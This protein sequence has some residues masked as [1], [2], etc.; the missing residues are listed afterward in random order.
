[1][2]AHR[3]G[4]DTAGSGA[5]SGQRVLEERTASGGG[6]VVPGLRPVAGGPEALR[7]A[8]PGASEHEGEEP[9]QRLRLRGNEPRRSAGRIR[10]VGEDLERAVL[11]EVAT[12]F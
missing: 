3:L 2:R 11:E 6:L 7:V 12:P 9:S 5:R 8:G 1:M 4:A 10:E